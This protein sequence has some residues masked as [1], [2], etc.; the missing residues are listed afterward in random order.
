[1][2]TRTLNLCG[3]YLGEKGDLVT[4]Q[5]SPIP[6]MSGDNPEGY[7]EHVGFL[8]CNLNILETLFGSIVDR[9][10]LCFPPGWVDDPRLQPVREHAQRL[11]GTMQG[12]WGW[13]DPRNTITLP[14]WQSLFPDL[15]VVVCLRNPLEVAQSLMKRGDIT[16]TESLLFWQHF[17]TRLA[18]SLPNSPYIV[19]HAASYYY[20]PSSEIARVATF[21]GLQPD[22]TMLHRATQSIV[23][24]HHRNVM[25]EFLLDK[26]DV[27]IKVRQQYAALSG[28]AGEV[29]ARLQA[30]PHAH[31]EQ[32]K[33]AL[34]GLYDHWCAEHT[35]TQ[36]V[37]S[38]PA[39][40]PQPTQPIEVLP[41]RRNLVSRLRGLYAAVVPTPIRL[42]GRKLRRQLL[43]R[44]SH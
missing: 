3:L 27:P 19:T 41:P 11:A 4:E 9:Y 37:T 24:A 42:R 40:E 17:H 14:F 13:K 2:I 23:A 36:V 12:E 32:L 34:S 22:E 38:A 25:P 35:R 5:S 39:A 43:R 26:A 30:D 8:G 7:W 20:D 21:I 28:Q 1:M 33:Q 31:I 10:E 29:Y 16:Q 15:K 6:M 18:E 44:E